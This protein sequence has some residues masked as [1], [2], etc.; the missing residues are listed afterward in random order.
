[1]GGR[2]CISICSWRLVATP[3]R[4]AHELD[5][6]VNQLYTRHQNCCSLH[7]LMLHVVNKRGL[8]SRATLCI[9]TRQMKA[10]RARVICLCCYIQQSEQAR[11]LCEPV[12]NRNAVLRI[13][14][15]RATNLFMHIALLREGRVPEVQHCLLDKRRDS[16][17]W[18]VSRLDVPLRS[19]P[20]HLGLVPITGQGWNGT[21]S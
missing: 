7:N 10:A 5:K 21:P 8:A 11:T 4:G 9:R 20:S 14:Q 19:C 6:H 1:M 18:T 13:L 12:Y 3:N 2:L 17:A 15:R 16:S